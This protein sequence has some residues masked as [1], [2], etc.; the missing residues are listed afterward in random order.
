M[1]AGFIFCAS[2][3]CIESRAHQSPVAD[4]RHA[5]FLFKSA[6]HCHRDSLKPCHLAGPSARLVGYKASVP[7]WV[8]ASA[9]SG[10]VSVTEPVKLCLETTGRLRALDAANQTVYTVYGGPYVTSNGPF[11][12]YMQVRLQSGRWG[13]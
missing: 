5:P 11:A 1:L 9:Q 2:L 3:T 13:A 4:V 12:A 7:V 10:N 6:V 8:A